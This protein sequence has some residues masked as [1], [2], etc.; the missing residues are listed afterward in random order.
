MK[1]SLIVLFLVLE[2]NLILGLIVFTGYGEEMIGGY[3]FQVLMNS[4][5]SVL[6]LEDGRMLF[7]I[8]TEVANE[9]Y[10]IV[11]VRCIDAMGSNLWTYSVLFDIQ[12][13][14]ITLNQVDE[15]MFALSCKDTDNRL[16]ILLFD[17]NGMG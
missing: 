17:S 3:S 11:E 12:G 1:K 15:N 14:S 2:V 6:F 9:Q 16:H 8:L 5:K 4:S 7:A 13:A 10:R